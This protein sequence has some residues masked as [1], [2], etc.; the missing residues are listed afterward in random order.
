ML[1]REIE[2]TWVYIINS[3]FVIIRQ[4]I[5]NLLSEITT[6]ASSFM[7]EKVASNSFFTHQWAEEYFAK[8]EIRCRV[9]NPGQW[10]WTCAFT[11]EEAGNRFMKK[12][13]K[14]IKTDPS[15]VTLTLCLNYLVWLMF[16]CK[17]TCEIRCRGLLQSFS[18]AESIGVIR[19]SDSL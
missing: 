4:E 19:T 1:F 12:S 16:F 13:P 14:R 5:C 9:S 10:S 3:I 11:S 17:T 18:A 8:P 7:D 2:V 15:F 6:V